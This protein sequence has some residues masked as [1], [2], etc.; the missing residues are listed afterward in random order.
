MLNPA[1]VARDLCDGPPPKYVSPF[2]RLYRPAPFEL[3]YLSWGR[4]R[5]GDWAIEAAMREGWHYFVVLAG[6]PTLVVGDHEIVTEPGAV[7]IGDPDCPIGHRDEPGGVCQMLTWIWRT[8]PTHSALRPDKEGYL[9]LYLEP[10]QL[11]RMK[12]LHVQCRE[13]VA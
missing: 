4:R 1:P 11:R 5:Y 7:S 13:A 8:P 10:A 9:R 2:V 12:Q 6:T 3:S